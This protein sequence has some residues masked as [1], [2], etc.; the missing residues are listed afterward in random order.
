VA[1]GSLWAEMQREHA[2]KRQKIAGDQDRKRLYSKNT[3]LLYGDPTAR[4]AAIDSTIRDSAHG[5]RPA[6]VPPLNWHV[7]GTPAA[8]GPETRV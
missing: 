5:P 8:G 2:L 3:D 1:E 6:R 7:S 4:V